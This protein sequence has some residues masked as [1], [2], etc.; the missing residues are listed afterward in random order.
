M[1]EE[2]IAV[3]YSEIVVEENKPMSTSQAATYSQ[4]VRI[5]KHDKCSNIFT[6]N[7]GLIKLH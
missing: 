6:L 1:L 4:T 3:A 5:P 2:D 7:K